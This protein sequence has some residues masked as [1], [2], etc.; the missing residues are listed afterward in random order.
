MPRAADLAQLGRN[1]HGARPG[2]RRRTRRCT[3]SATRNRRRGERARRAPLRQPP[4]GAKATGR[5]ALPQDNAAA[6]EVYQKALDPKFDRR[7]TVGLFGLS[8]I[9]GCPEWC[10]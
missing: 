7:R 3:G 8:G 10:D 9:N 5:T 2:L 4:V 1:R 6:R